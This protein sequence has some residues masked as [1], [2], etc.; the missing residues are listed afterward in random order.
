LVWIN[1]EARI[2]VQVRA[3]RDLAPGKEMTESDFDEVYSVWPE[4]VG[5]NS[6]YVCFAI[7]MDRQLVKFDFRYNK[8][9]VSDLFSR[10]ICHAEP[11]QDCSP[12]REKARALYVCL[13]KQPHLEVCRERATDASLA[14]VFASR[15]TL[16]G[17]TTSAGHARSSPRLV[18]IRDNSLLFEQVRP[19]RKG[20]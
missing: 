14:V 20:A 12:R 4:A 7:L 10:A 1:Q 15:K 9:R 3:T 18:T 11:A 16:L 6:G 2:V 19:P 8:Q 13:P 17:T 5:P